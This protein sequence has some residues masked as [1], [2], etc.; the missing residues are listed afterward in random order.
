MSIV[1]SCPDGVNYSIFCTKDELRAL[2][3]KVYEEAL[4]TAKI[5]AE[6]Q[7]GVKYVEEMKIQDIDMVIAEI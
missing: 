5:E 6:N 3:S 4:A 7:F 2:L 1:I